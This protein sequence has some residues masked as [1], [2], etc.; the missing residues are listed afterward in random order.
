MGVKVSRNTA[1]TSTILNTSTV[2]LLLKSDYFH[3]RC[4]KRRGEK[5][6]ESAVLVKYRAIQKNLPHTEFHLSLWW[7][8]EAGQSC[9]F[10]LGMLADARDPLPPGA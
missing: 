7:A 3:P 5:T 2:T 1:G 10:K 9:F 8:E 4:I 6:G